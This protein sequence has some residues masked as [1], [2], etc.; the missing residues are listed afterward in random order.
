MPGETGIGAN[1]G[2]DVSTA[3]SAHELH[4][5]PHFATSILS[6]E[7]IRLVVMTY[8]RFPPSRRNV[9]DRLLER[10]I[11]ICHETV[12]LWWNR[13]GPPFAGDIRP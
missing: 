11:D 5:S 13:F 7:M 8:V 3:K 1:Q 10:G 2:P 4:R 6:P 12:R 9:E